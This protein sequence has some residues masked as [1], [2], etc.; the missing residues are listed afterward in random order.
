MFELIQ[1]ISVL[2]IP[3]LVIAYF[4]E[5]WDFFWANPTEVLRN[6]TNAVM[7]QVRK[8][9][10]L[11]AKRILALVIL[12]GKEI[13]LKGKE[14]LSLVFYIGGQA[15]QSVENLLKLISGILSGFN[16][17]FTTTNTI[18]KIIPLEYI[19]FF[20]FVSCLVLLVTII[21]QKIKKLLKED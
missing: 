7:N 11:P 9:L 12:A 16:R 18:D 20:L 14:I 5:I 13:L 1:T 4:R 10:I 8:D 17:I 6:V 3:A 15:I 2:A 21:L 19:W